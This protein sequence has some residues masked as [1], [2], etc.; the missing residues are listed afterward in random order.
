MSLHH[1]IDKLPFYTTIHDSLRAGGHFVFADELTGVVPYIQRLHW[2]D[3]LDFASQPGHL[4]QQELDDLLRHCETLDH[5]E[6][7]PDQLALLS[8]AGFGEVDCI[9]RASNYAIFAAANFTYD[10][11]NK[12]RY[13]EEGKNAQHQQAGGHIT[14]PSTW[15][16]HQH[17]HKRRGDNSHRGQ[18]GKRRQDE[19]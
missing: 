10:G 17:G 7:L 11:G 5:Y 3:W 19:Q 18:F 6:T 4:S 1:L 14:S 9:W 15:T 13:P 16:E 2:S 8:S 12:K